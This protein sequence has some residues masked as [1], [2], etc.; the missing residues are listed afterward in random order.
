M[1]SNGSEGGRP[2]EGA[3]MAARPEPREGA[4]D[5][6]SPDGEDGPQGP[7]GRGKGSA[8]FSALLGVQEGG[9]GSPRVTLRPV[10]AGLG[11]RLA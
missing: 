11:P 10:A 2:A 8:L 5:E 4:Q 3:A 1:F 9:P 7:A 6:V